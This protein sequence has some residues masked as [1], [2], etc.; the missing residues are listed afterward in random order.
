[1]ISANWLIFVVALLVG[2]A[3]AYW[4]FGRAS[5]PAPRQHRPDVLDEGAAPAQRNQALIDDA[6]PAA[7]FAAPSVIDPPAPAGTMARTGEVIAVAAQEE[8]DAGSTPPQTIAAEPAEAETAVPAPNASAPA[9][10][11][12]DDLRKIKGLGPK[13]LTLLNALGINRFEQIA[14]WTEADLD[15][16]DGKLGAFAGRPRRDSWVEQA[17]LLSGGDTGA[18]EAKFG[19]L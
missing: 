3:I 9:E 4:L 13:M 10:A 8:G 16:L 11:A 17:R 7:Q 2:I 15:E 1:M 12:G 18:Y 6:P 14:A 5:K 19:K